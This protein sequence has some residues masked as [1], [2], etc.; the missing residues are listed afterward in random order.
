MSWFEG[1][2]V[3]LL[4][5]LTP[6]SGSFLQCILIP[7]WEYLKEG[8]YQDA[9]LYFQRAGSA[10]RKTAPVSPLGAFLPINAK[11]LFGVSFG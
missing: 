8:E 9:K 3:K 7:H 11:V 2:Y 1:R 10:Y 5:K 6:G 4:H